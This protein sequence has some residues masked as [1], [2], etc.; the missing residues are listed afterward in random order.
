M[1]GIING[2]VGSMIGAIFAIGMFCNY[3]VRKKYSKM[4]STMNNSGQDKNLLIIERQYRHG[5]LQ[6]RVERIKIFVEKEYYE[7]KICGIPLYVFEDFT[8][9]SVYFVALLGLTFTVIQVALPQINVY[10]NMIKIF[11]LSIE[12]LI[13]GTILMVYRTVLG[14]HSL[15]EIFKINLC[16]YLEYELELFDEAERDE[17]GNLFS[18]KSHKNFKKSKKNNKEDNQNIEPRGNN[19]F[20]LSH[21][22]KLK[23]NR[24]EEDFDEFDLLQVLEEILG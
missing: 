3:V 23:E 12:G 22:R 2:V 17:E 11:F 10:S 5:Y 9:S 24:V 18:E 4:N 19:V 15:R 13:L 21:D 7:I 20:N 1:T 6:D 14:I 8:I 16:N